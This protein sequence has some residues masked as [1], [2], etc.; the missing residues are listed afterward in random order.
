MKTLFC[1]AFILIFVCLGVN[2]LFESGFYTSHDG[3]THIARI[4]NYYLA[5]KDGQIPP[6]WAGN[7]N[8][9]AGS[10]IFVYIYP[11]PYFLGV[12]LHF[13]G[14]SFVDSFKLITTAGYGLSGIF[15]FFWIK[16][17]L[18]HKSGLLAAILYTWAPYRFSQ[19][20][21]RGAY[22]ESLAYAVVPLVFW[23]IDQLYQT[24]DKKW[25]AIGSL[26]VGILMLLHNLVAF[27]FLPIATIYFILLIFF[28]RKE[29]IKNTCYLILMFVLGAG[30][31]AVTYLPYIFE[32]D[33]VS[34]KNLIT[35]YHEH[36]IYWNQYFRSPWGYGFSFKG[37]GDN[38]S[39]QIGLA[40]ILIVLMSVPLFVYQIYKRK[41]YGH[42]NKSAFFLSWFGV[43]IL[44]IMLLL[45]T[46]STVASFLWEKLTFLRIVDYP[47]RLLGPITFAI[48]LIG[49]SLISHITHNVIKNSLLLFFLCALLIANRN[50]LRINEKVFWTDKHF[51]EYSGSSTHL[52]EFTPVTRSA[53][54][55][56]QMG[57]PLK[58]RS[59]EIRML[60]FERN[61]N[62]Q[63]YLMDVVSPANIQINTLYFPGWEVI[64]NGR[65]LFFEKD[66]TLAGDV[67]LPTHIDNRGMIVVP[68]KSSGTYNIILKFGETPVRRAANLIS[69]ISLSIVTSILISRYVTL[70]VK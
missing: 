43:G 32:V 37:T 41:L 39:F 12:I 7:L 58:I 22:A 60:S 51:L 31:A 21:V 57:G 38:M 13:L 3:E 55:F 28:E 49:G 50:H 1:L 29:R 9:G 8:F 11:L 67:D 16:S 45:A 23:A 54:S 20:L 35:Y 40:H 52:G 48:A 44:T 33:F 10:P 46:E 27:I 15:M 61:S 30:I 69:L 53:T 42:V 62:Y 2:D 36:F 64:L 18:G 63:Q 65:K 14:F 19:I 56:Q 6:R 34:F 47:W 5:L 17:I 26:S 70:K 24:Q 25:F 4:A 59:G 66:F 68:I